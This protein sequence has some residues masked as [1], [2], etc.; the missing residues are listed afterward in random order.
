MYLF[1]YLFIYF[2]YLLILFY[3]ILFILFY[4]F[5][6]F[7]YLINY[8][9]YRK[10]QIKIRGKSREKTEREYDQISQII[11]KKYYL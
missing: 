2:T 7:I 10:E 6:Y 3:F 9:V 1:I 4:L 5:D 11:K 8:K